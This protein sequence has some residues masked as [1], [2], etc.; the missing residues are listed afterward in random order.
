MICEL[1]HIIK[2]FDN[3]SGQDKWSY[4]LLKNLKSGIKFAQ[5]AKKTGLFLSN[6]E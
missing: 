6:L 2:M 4:K 1:N 5:T 3:T